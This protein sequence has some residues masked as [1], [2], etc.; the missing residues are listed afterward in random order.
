MPR[1]KPRQRSRYPLVRIEWS[2]AESDDPWEDVKTLRESITRQVV[3]AGFLILETDT[4]LVLG[5][6]YGKND[7]ETEGRLTIPK[8]WITKLTKL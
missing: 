6:S 7:D 2:D 3:S 4:S 1:R 8:S 5:R